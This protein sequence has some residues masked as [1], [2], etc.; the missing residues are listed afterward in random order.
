[1]AVAGKREAHWGQSLFE[2]AIQT[3]FKAQQFKSG[4]NPLKITHQIMDKRNSFHCSLL[5]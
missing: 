1:M 3:L 2:A 4:N 5:P